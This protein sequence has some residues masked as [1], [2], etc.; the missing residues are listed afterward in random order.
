[1]ISPELLEQVRHIEDTLEWE[2]YKR[3]TK[4][5]EAT[6]L[7]RRVFACRE[8]QG[9][10]NCS[11]CSASI[12]CTLAESHARNAK[13]GVKEEPDEPR[14]KFSSYTKDPSSGSD[15]IPG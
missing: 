8:A 13:Y 2:G 1:M 15:P 7:A 10:R 3:G 6:A 12:A 14:S 9:V 4:L 11:E 5:F